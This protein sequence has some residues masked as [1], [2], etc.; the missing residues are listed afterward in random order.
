MPDD[1]SDGLRALI[2]QHIR[3]VPDFPQPG[4]LFRDITPLLSAP[5]ALSRALGWLCERADGVDAVVG[6]EARGFIL[7]A[8][9]AQRL[10]APFVPIRKAGKLPRATIGRAYGLE[11]GQDSI[12]IHA[13]ALAAGQRV[14][15]IDDLLATGGTAR[16]AAG[17]IAA[18][19]A[20][21]AAL[22]FLIELADLDGRAALAD[23]SQVIDALLSY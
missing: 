8:P 13:D 15:L 12:E 4:I 7:G 14:A 2:A 6:I 9:V 3:A 17:L 16:A 21:I 23:H 5:D 20:E 22:T 10:G 19:G 11:Y 18:T 1:P